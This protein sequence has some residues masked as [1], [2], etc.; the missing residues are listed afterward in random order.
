MQ[1][2][3]D[4]DWVAFECGSSVCGGGV[5]GKNSKLHYKNVTIIGSDVIV[6]TIITVI[7]THHGT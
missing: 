1:G 3:K 6:M 5:C 7:A 2:D 4:V